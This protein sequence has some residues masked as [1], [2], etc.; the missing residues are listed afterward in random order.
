MVC[1]SAAITECLEDSD[2]CCPSSCDGSTDSD[3]AEC[4]NT[5]IEMGET[6]DGDC[7]TSCDDNDNC[8]ADSLTGSSQDCDVVCQNDPVTECTAG[9]SCCPSGCTP[10]NDADCQPTQIILD[11]IHRGWWRNDGV[12]TA[13]N[14]NTLTGQDGGGQQFN[15]YFIF[16]L[17]GVTGTV[18]SAE[19][20]MEVEQYSSADSQETITIWD[21]T[22]NTTTLEA[23]GPS[24]PIYD[25]LMTGP[26]YGAF[27]V[28]S[29]EVGQIK[30]TPLSTGAVAQVQAA[31]GGTFAVGLH[32]S[33]IGGTSSQWVRF[34]GSDEQRTHQL[35]ISAY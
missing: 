10:G 20:H 32:N 9:D 27:N 28:Q 23:D 7:P 4:G 2:G 26:Q 6:C 22:T 5:V 25:D 17:A 29:G 16:D 31:L 35:V 33:S 34:S 11:A 14:N 13:S 24:I 12:H 15:S 18:V 19:L 1:T 3:C 21:V 8:T 30:V